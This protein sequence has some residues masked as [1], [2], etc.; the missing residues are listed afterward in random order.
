MKHQF[1]TEFYFIR[2]APVVKREGYL[3]P[4]DPPIKEGPFDL[5]PLKNRL[6][7]NADWYISPLLRARQ[8]ADLLMADLVPRSVIFDERLVE[9]NFGDW[10]DKPLAEVW[11]EIADAPRHN[12]S[13]IMPHTQPPGGESF[14]ALCKR[15]ARW[16]DDKVAQPV[17]NPQIII[18]HAGVISAVLSHILGI[19][20]QRAIGV[21]VANFSVLQTS[22]MATGRAKDSGG[23]WQL[24][25]FG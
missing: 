12:W 11:A 18:T 15:I 25:S 23:P 24:V 22:L 14:I 3:P 17:T 16:L 4:H 19:S 13:F 21:A 2:H 8:T 10:H 6:P 5:A 7:K 9:M 20:P 1:I